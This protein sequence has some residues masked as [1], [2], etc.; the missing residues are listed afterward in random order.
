MPILALAVGFGFIDN[1]DNL[2]LIQATE[3]LSE[4]ARDHGCSHILSSS[5]N[6]MVCSQQTC[7]QTVNKISKIARKT[8]ISVST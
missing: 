4:S 6:A 3:E 8:S 5:L 1:A 7:T 2:A